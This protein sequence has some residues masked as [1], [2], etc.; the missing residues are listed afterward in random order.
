MIEGTMDR[1]VPTDEKT[2]QHILEIQLSE[3]R[4]K[5]VI[6]TGS[7]ITLLKNLPN[8]AERARVAGFERVRIQTHGMHLSKQ[9][10]VKELLNSGINEF[11]ISVAGGNEEVHDAITT[12]RGSFSKMMKGIENIESQSADTIII[13]NTVVTKQS[14]QTLP[15]IVDLLAPYSN[16]VQH[17]FWNYFPMAQ[18]DVKD[19]IVPYKELLPHIV[20]TIQKCAASR[21]GVEVKNVPHCLLGK[22][23]NAL[24][25][26]QPI[27]YI[28]ENFWTEFDR[29]AFNQCYYRSQCESAVCLG[30]TDAYIKKFGWEKDFLRPLKL[31]DL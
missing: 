15:Q 27:L 26:A 22:W 9:G 28:D 7:E 20:M 16:V 2:F 6:L 21:R 11:F 14:Y 1:L 24:V 29:N 12:V 23:K 25:N 8:L 19:L 13:T 17:E 4:W 30:L 31:N 10:Y 3:K 18:T 5:G